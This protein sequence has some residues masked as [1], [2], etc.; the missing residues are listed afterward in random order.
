MKQGRIRNFLK[1]TKKRRRKFGRLRLRWEQEA[2]II[3]EA[4]NEVMDVK[5]E[6]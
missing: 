5:G 3:Y 1:E 4:E 6:Q 2:E